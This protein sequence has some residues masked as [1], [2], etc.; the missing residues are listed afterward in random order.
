MRTALR[1][2]AFVRTR[3]RFSQIAEA[4]KAQPGA[5]GRFIGGAPSAMP[6]WMGIRIR[7]R[8]CNI[9]RGSACF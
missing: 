8:Q 3:S 2:G 4:G 5:S 7:I 6:L 1:H 9:N